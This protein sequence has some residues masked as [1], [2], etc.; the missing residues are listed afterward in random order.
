MTNILNYLFP[1][2]MAAT[3]P[4][5][6]HHIKLTDNNFVA[7]RTQIDMDTVSKAQ[8]EMA[9]I[10]SKRGNKDYVIYLVLDSP[11]GSIDAGLD[12]IES[13]KTIPKLETV[14]LF[15]A[16]MASAIVEALPGK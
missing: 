3:P 2:L 5:A 13:F 6:D 14:T 11:G 10:V 9:E 15:A 1:L 12:L 8:L 16:S 4:P 7:I